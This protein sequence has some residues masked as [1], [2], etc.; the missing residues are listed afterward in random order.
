MIDF[1]NIYHV[2]CDK[3]SP[4]EKATDAKVLGSK[5]LQLTIRTRNE[6][7]DKMAF[8]GKTM[9]HHPTVNIVN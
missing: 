7:R 1:K 3:V 9:S 5:I 6:L 4:P 2:N 8:N